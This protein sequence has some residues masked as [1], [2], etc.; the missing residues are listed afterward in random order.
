MSVIAEFSIP[1]S[2]FILGKALQEAPEFEVTI[3]RAIPV[4]ESVIPYVWAYGTDGGEFESV[5]A[6]APEI[7]E[8][9]IVD[10]L[11]SQALYRLM[12]NAD[13]DTF[14]QRVVSSN[15]VLQ[16][17]VGDDE[18]WEF[19]LRFPDSHE[20][21]EFHTGCQDAGMDVTV[22]SLYNP[23]EP[24]TVNTQKMTEAQ[25]TLVER[26][27]D[28]GYFD[29]PRSITLVELAEELGISDQSVNERLRRGLSALIAATLKPDRPEMD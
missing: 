1:A 13:V 19:Q 5:L 15:T 10:E 8:Y 23:I 28:E 3:E 24:T 14:L 11:D 26:A 2:Q 18:R 22:E 27:Y 29:V 17:A 21:S 7:D 4:G 6:R 25:L 16:Q 20:L 9:E 12:W